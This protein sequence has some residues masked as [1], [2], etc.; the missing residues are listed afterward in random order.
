MADS[1]DTLLSVGSSNSTNQQ[2]AV[3]RVNTYRNC[4]Q[5]STVSALISM[6]GSSKAIDDAVGMVGLPPFNNGGSSWS[7]AM[8][9]FYS[10]VK[11]LKTYPLPTSSTKCTVANTVIV[12]LDKELVSIDKN[13]AIGGTDDNFNRAYTAAVN[14]IKQYYTAWYATSDCDI[15]I[16]EQASEYQQQQTNKNTQTNADLLSR[17]TQTSSSSNTIVYVIGGVLVFGL[18]VTVILLKRKSD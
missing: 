6:Q 10:L 2:E 11:Y 1:L 12:A 14:A 4:S 9:L 3:A 13:R 7:E 15:K 16:T 18:I 17:E 5:Y 8:L